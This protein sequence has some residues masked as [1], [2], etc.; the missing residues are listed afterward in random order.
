MEKYFQEQQCKAG[1]DN[2][3]AKAVP[4]AST[5]AECKRLGRGLNF[6]LG[7]WRRK[8]DAQKV[9]YKAIY[10]KFSQ[11]EDL[12]QFLLENGDT[13]MIVAN[14]YYK[15]W[16][17]GLALKDINQLKDKNMWKGLNKLGNILKDV[18][19]SIRT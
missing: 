8:G 10:A 17:V 1:N 18:K 2:C 5:T 6:Y 9:M 19:V 16:G 11:N 12:K 14:P 3:L 7:E 4:E 15:Y 13:E